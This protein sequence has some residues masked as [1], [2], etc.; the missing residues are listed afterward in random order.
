MAEVST[1]KAAM[2][3]AGGKYSKVLLSVIVN[4]ILARI[5]SADDYG[6]V[7]VITVFSTLFTTLSDMGF[8]TAIIQRKDLRKDEIDDIYSFTVYL[9]LFLTIVFCLCAYPIA[10]FY[11]NKAYIP[12]GLLLSISLFFNALNMV[13]NGILNREKKFVSIAVRTVAVYVV[14]SIITV[15]LAYCGLRYYALIFQAIISA[16]LQF[17]WNFITTRPKFHFRF[18]MGSVKKIFSYSGFQFAF[19]LVNYFS[20]N[21]DNLLTGKY[22]GNTEL[23]FYNKAYTL[24]LYPVNNLAGVVSPVLHPILSDY[25]DQKEIIYQKHMKIVRLFLC[26]GLYVSLLCYLGAEEVV[27]ILYGS[28]WQ[29]SVICFQ[30]LSL[31]IATQ[32]VNSSAGAVYQAIGNTRLLFLNSCIN[33]VITVVAICIGVFWGESI[34]ILSIC[35]SIAYIF[36]FLTAF[37]MLVRFGFQY[38]L[39]RF[40]KEISSEIIVL[41]VLVAAVIVYPF[42]VN[43]IFLSFLLKA[44]YLSIPFVITLLLTKEIRLFKWLLKK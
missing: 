26:I 30:Y 29:E 15:I 8:G 13:P 35:V 34:A 4:A 22:V 2:I 17:G 11:E 24:M 42:Q 36:H 14:S 37:F 23:G 1:K 40:V 32:M 38:S 21:L 27:N 6:I 44:V 25:Q 31:A 7:A 18:N 5:L 28:N 3:N 12:L 20:R 16:F 9:S 41:L 10:I 33:T 43:Q 19:N 39:L